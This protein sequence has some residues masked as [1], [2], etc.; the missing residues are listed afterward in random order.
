[1]IQSNRYLRDEA[2]RHRMLVRS[3]L[4]SAAFE[5]ARHLLAPGSVAALAKLKP[6]SRI[7]ASGR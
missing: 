2:K 4:E 6:S 3:T 5:G 1:M 7:A